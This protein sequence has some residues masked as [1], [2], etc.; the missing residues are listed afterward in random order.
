MRTIAI[1]LCGLFVTSCISH[2]KLP[3]DW[4]LPQ[5]APSVTCPD[6]SGNYDSDGEC[7]DKSTGSLMMKLFELKEWY[8]KQEDVTHVSIHQQ[9]QDSIYLV[10][11]KD[12]EVLYSKTL[13][14]KSGDFKCKDGWI[15]IT[16]AGGGIAG[17]TFFGAIY[18]ERTTKS[19][20][21]SDGYL[22]MKDENKA[23]GIVI[24]P[25]PF[26]FA[27]SSV[28][29]CRFETPPSG[30]LGSIVVGGNVVSTT[31][32]EN[33]LWGVVGKGPWGKGWG[34]IIKID[35]NTNQLTNLFSVDSFGGAQIAAGAGAVWVAE[36]LGGDKILRID[37]TSNR[38]VAT[39]SVDKNP[40]G[41][42]VGEGAVW[43]TAWKGV[44]KVLGLTWKVYG[45]AIYKIDPETNRV[46]STIDV[47]QGSHPR[48][49]YLQAMLAVGSGAVWTGDA[50]NG[51]VQRLDPQTN[52]I[53]AT[54]Q[55]P[56]QSASTEPFHLY[57]LVT[58][59]GTVLLVRRAYPDGKEKSVGGITIWRI[60]PLTNKFVGD[61]IEIDKKDSVISFDDGTY[62]IGSSVEDAVTRG[63]LQTLR[64]VGEPKQ[65][66]HPVYAIAAGNGTVW[67]IGR[68]TK[69][70][71]SRLT[72]FAP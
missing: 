43:V 48:N 68:R 32:T 58:T 1:I 4:S 45:Q 7:A 29:W 5:S 13:S 66:G 46:V 55:I 18:T 47:P 27:G 63:D 6:I 37:P 14:M 56:E 69:W 24:V 61:P 8:G 30:V 41:I 38:I 22:L 39:I 60:D 10:A 40:M 70:G 72:R 65:V 33:A 11:W 51:T 31:F 34:N 44:P 20:A 71:N 2:Q 57:S 15:E 52:Q 67:A 19:F 16:S 59:Q 23:V 42:A 9:D 50:W 21:K 28:A 49:I 36:G 17:A 53:V 26:P 62:W 54:I 35:L 25:I 64:P 3:A 12:N